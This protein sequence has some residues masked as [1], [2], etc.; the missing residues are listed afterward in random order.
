M[1]NS[2]HYKF[3]ACPYVKRMSKTGIKTRS[4][5]VIIELIY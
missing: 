2:L 5:Y 1:F 4:I 3:F